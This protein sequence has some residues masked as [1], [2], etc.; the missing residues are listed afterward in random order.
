[1]DDGSH[2]SRILAFKSEKV[3][4]LEAGQKLNASNLL[5]ESM[6]KAGNRVRITARLVN[7]KDKRRF[8]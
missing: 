2:I 6:R 5:E 7:V 4:S 3:D 1:M 8:R